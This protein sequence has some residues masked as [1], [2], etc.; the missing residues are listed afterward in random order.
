MFV[1]D[2]YPGFG[3]GAEGELTPGDTV[4]GGVQPP[5][6]PLVAAGGPAE[7]GVIGPNP[8]PAAY[9]GVGLTERSHKSRRRRRPL[10]TMLQ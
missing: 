6:E 3:F 9:I 2:G 8:Q 4:T 5:K 7:G 10:S 1:L